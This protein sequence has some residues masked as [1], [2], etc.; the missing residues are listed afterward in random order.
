[1]EDSRKADPQYTGFGAHGT[2]HQD[3]I[4]T[5]SSAG[6]IR[7]YNQDVIDL[8]DRVPV[9]ANVVVRSALGTAA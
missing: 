6:C 9:G 2:P 4:C 7:M 5:Q 3:T 8:E 1:M